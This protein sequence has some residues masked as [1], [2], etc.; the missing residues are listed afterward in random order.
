MCL[1]PLPIQGEITTKQLDIMNIEYV[2]L[3]DDEEKTSAAVA[4][5]CDKAVSGGCPVALIAP[6]GVLAGEKKPTTPDT[7]YPMSRE[8]AIETVLDCMPSDTVY[9][10]T[11]GRATREIYFLR[12]RRNEPHSCDFL[13][14]G[15]MGHASS[16]ALGIALA[17]KNRS[18]VCFDGDSA[19]IMHMGAFTMVSKLNVPNF[20]H[21]VLNN[22]AH[23]SVGGQPSAFEPKP[24][25]NLSITRACK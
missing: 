14:V 16:V 23:E 20:L 11:T 22:G 18:V 9:S 13:N 4:W 7:C 21:I 1:S 17:E 12:E 5:A 19:S 15:S 6:K 2:V 3:A 24:S 25:L 8:E 10:A